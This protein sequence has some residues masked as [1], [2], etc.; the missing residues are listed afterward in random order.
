MSSEPDHS[1]LAGQL[2]S[3]ALSQTGDVLLALQVLVQAGSALALTKLTP[4]AFALDAFDGAY[5]L[6]R[7]R[8]AEVLGVEE[9]RQ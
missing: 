6:G 9:P 8:L 4:A 5:L 1:V 3:A 2:A 7:E